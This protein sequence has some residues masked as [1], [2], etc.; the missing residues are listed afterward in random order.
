M[1]GDQIIRNAH[2]QA[3]CREHG[4]VAARRK[5]EADA[6]R[7]IEML[8]VGVQSAIDAAPDV[9]GGRLDAGQAA[10]LVVAALL[11]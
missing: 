10:R 7:Q 11:S 9:F 1:Y 2:M 3:L 4:Q 8:E 5:G 6:R